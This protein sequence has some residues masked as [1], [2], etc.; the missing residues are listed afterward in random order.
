[1]GWIRLALMRFDI[2]SSSALR[3]GFNYSIKLLSIC[4]I[5]TS[6]VGV[7]LSF[8]I[9]T[10]RW[11][12]FSVAVASY[13]LGIGLHRLSSVLLRVRDKPHAL[14][15]LE[16][17]RTLF[18]LLFVTLAT[19]VVAREFIVAILATA[20]VSILFAILSI[21]VA[22]D[23]V[24]LE[25]PVAAIAIRGR[26]EFGLPIFLLAL[27][28]FAV[29]GSDRFLIKWLFNAEALGIY[30][31]AYALGRQPM[32][33]VTNAVGLGSLPE[34][35]RR[36]D[37]RGREDAIEYFN[38]VLFFNLLMLVPIALLLWGLAGPIV[39]LILPP[40]YY[41]LGRVV[42]PLAGLGSL[43]RC[44]KGNVL[45]HVFVVT[46]NTWLQV[47]TYIPAAVITIVLSFWFIKAFGPEGAAWAVIVG[48][49]IG[50][51]LGVAII[52]LR[53]SW[54]LSLFSLAGERSLE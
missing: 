32:E 11:L 14:A 47:I 6:L 2:G 30:S 17:A 9:V 23:G 27:A 42:L 52:R 4:W 26:I 40:S 20:S 51:M 3:S 21:Y 13:T 43:V 28:T 46:R 41:E 24:S 15:I 45:D 19:L 37:S 38:K 33:V 31:A 1:M 48:A 25:E 50:L 53:L 22:L 29:T 35:I 18:T 54:G 12:A 7:M 36:M 16:S 49:C 44:L 10:D 39:A 8:A 34:L 5:A